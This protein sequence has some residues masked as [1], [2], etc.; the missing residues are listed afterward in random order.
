MALPVGL[1]DVKW[2]ALLVAAIANIVLGFVW[3]NPKTPT[4]RVWMKGSGQSMD[5]KPAGAEMTQMMVITL[6]TAFLVTGVLGLVFAL[7]R[8]A[9]GADLSVADGVAGALLVW[10]GFFLPLNLGSVA[11]ERKPWSYALVVTAYW[12]VTLVIAGVVYATMAY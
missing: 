1:G 3:Y 10:G 4:G 6:A 12:L 9:A 2:T 8:D 11:Y 7:L 5:T